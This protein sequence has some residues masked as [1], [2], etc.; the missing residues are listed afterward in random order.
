MHSLN[1]AQTG[2]VL[3]LAI[4]IGGAFVLAQGLI[5]KRLRELT[6]EGTSGYGSPPNV[7]YI[8]NVVA[9]KADAQ[10]GF[11][12]LV[13]GFSVQALDYLLVDQSGPPRLSAAAVAL[14]AVVSASAVSLVGR[15]I[16]TALLAHHRSEMVRH[17]LTR[18]SSREAGWIRLVVEHLAP[19]EAQGAGESDDAFVQRIVTK[20]VP[21]RR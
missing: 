1:Y 6:L 10:V 8:A 2:F 20:F 5:A 18:S 14:I 13:F 4:E 19:Q 7:R 12:T 21:A 17:V 15:V 16:R 11:S 9:Q 3:G